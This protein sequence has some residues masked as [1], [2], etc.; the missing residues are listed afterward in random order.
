VQGLGIMKHEMLHILNNHCTIRNYNAENH[1]IWN[2]AYDCAINQSINRDHLPD[3]CVYPD[4]INAPVNKSGEQYYDF[5]K[6]NAQ[7]QMNESCDSC[8]GSGHSHEDCGECN[9]T[10]QDSNGDTCEHC[11]GSGK[12]PCDDC[13]G[14]GRKL[15]PLDDHSKWQE[16]EGNDELR[17][18]ITKNMIEKAMTKSRGNLP[19]DIDL[20]LEMFTRKAQ[21]SWQKELRNIVGNR[22]ANK[23][24]T[25]MK[26]NRRQPHRLDLKG[27]K[28]DRVFELV[29][30]A[31]VSGSVSNRELMTGLNE[32][33]EICKLTNT[34]MKLLQIDTE[35]HGVE[36]F[37]KKTKLINRKATGG[38]IM[39]GGIEYLRDKKIPYDALILI[40]DGYIE[41]ISKWEHPPKKKM[42]FLVTNESQ[43]IPGIGVYRRYKQFNLK[44]S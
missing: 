20:M 31:D 4:T 7:Q 23:T 12:E 10:G 5:L 6:D 30:M 22:K 38:T 39:E 34:S 44:V 36:E 21:V 8:G 18:D 43:N 16:S 42:M 33:H 9:G 32:I 11:N 14:T 19:H 40:T 3:F 24:A 17:K 35:V 27:T 28:K 13:Q 25:I 26:P 2:I 29:V 1:E 37:S 41:D 15:R